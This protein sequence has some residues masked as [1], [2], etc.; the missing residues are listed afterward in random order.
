MTENSSHVVNVT[1]Q[2]P[3]ES[4]HSLRVDITTAL[5]QLLVWPFVYIDL[6]MFFVFLRRE[7]LRVETRYVLFAQ[8]L[9]GDCFFLVLTNFVVLTVHVHLLLPVAFCVPLCIVMDGL[10]H[11]SPTVIVAMCLERYVAICMPL[12]HVNIFTPKRT[13][14]VIAAVWVLSFIKPFLDFVIF[15]NAVSTSYYTQ[16]TF[17]YYEI[18]LLERWHL[19]MRGNLYIANYL[20]IL[21]ILF[22][23]YGSIIVVA[24][25]ASGDNK[26]V[27]S[28]AKR[29]L[30]LHLLQLSLCTVEIICPYVEAQVL[31]A[32]DLYIYM[33][34]R[35]FNF[36]A[37]SILSRAI[38]PLIYGFRDEK[39]Y[40]AIKYYANCNINQ[41]TSDK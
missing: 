12:Q 22:F 33:I 29:T 9:L 7:V 37:F 27:A 24:H 34:V 4:P 21:I 8:T 19:M 38:S 35:S 20:L 6:F 3:L 13:T 16:M 11:L 23:C 18:M 32:A 25:R 5:I 40:A 39:F 41:I 30:L 17:C 14:T 15:L 2:E 1:V 28:K 36:L 10:T 31:K 26:T